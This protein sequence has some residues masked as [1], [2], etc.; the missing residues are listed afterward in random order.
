MRMCDSYTDDDRLLDLL[1]PVGAQIGDMLLKTLFYARWRR[2][3]EGG[4]FDC[5]TANPNNPCPQLAG[6]VLIIRV[7][8]H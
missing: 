1:K 7:A 2:W 3:V 8:S 5:G 4:M 6:N